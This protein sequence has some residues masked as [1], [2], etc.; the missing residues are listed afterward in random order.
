MLYRIFTLLPRIFDSFWQSSLIARGLEKE[1]IKYELVNYREQFAHG[2][3]RQVDDRPFGGGSG[4]VLQVE[5][6][7]K[8]L[9]H[10]K[11]V[12]GLFK[13]PTKE[14]S[15][16]KIVPNNRKFMEAVLNPQLKLYKTKKVTILL[17]PRGFPLNQ[18]QL[19]FL[20]QNFQ[21]INILCGRYEGFD[22][23]VS[24]LVDLEI[25]IGNF[26]TNGGEVPAM[27]LIEGVS[28]LIPGFIT[29][30]TSVLHD[31]FSKELN[32]HREESLYSK[33]SRPDHNSLLNPKQLDFLFDDEFWKKNILPRIE[34]PQ[35]SRPEVWNNFKVPEVLLSGDHKA[36]SNWRLN[37]YK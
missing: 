5:P 28:R 21:E 1:I 27:A 23:R 10:Y 20:S 15:H 29:K 31:S 9:S 2:N 12:S 30:N 8:A 17:T 34:H 37:W 22:H 4:M 18:I 3:Y 11:A 32:F 33:K 24:E 7:F 25:S 6:I 35:Y 13:L 26:V 14:I 36:I 16:N 19:E